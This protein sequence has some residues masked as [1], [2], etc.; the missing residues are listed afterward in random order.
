MVR[1]WQIGA[2]PEQMPQ[3]SASDLTLHCL[4]RPL[5]LNIY[6]IH[7]SQK[8]I[9]VIFCTDIYPMGTTEQNYLTETIP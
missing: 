3:Y 7:G 4:L 5:C 9:F 1:L 6:S 8:I 2:E